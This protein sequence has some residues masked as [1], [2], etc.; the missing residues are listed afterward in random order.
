MGFML[1]DKKYPICGE[2]A[3]AGRLAG[4]WIICSQG[5]PQL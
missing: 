4:L 1:L 5:Y 3:W 2:A